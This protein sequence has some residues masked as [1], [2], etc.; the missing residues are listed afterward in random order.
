MQLPLQGPPA[1]IGPSCWG[2]ELKEGSISVTLNAHPT[3]STCRTFYKEEDHEAKSLGQWG[4]GNLDPTNQ[5]WI[6]H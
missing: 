1:E 3:I 4:G 6:A 2:D 5:I